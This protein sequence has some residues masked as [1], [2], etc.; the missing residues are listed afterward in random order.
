[1]SRGIISL[2][3]YLSKSLITPSQLTA[4]AKP[5][6]SLQTHPDL[7]FRFP[8]DLTLQQQGGWGFTLPPEAYS[9]ALHIQTVDQVTQGEW[10][11]TPSQSNE[12]LQISQSHYSST[13]VSAEI[14]CLATVLQLL[15]RNQKNEIYY[16]SPSK[17]SVKY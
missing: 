7:S 4:P 12:G 17:K 9:M 13:N 16:D 2:P 15:Y 8:V 3:E 6:L 5:C 11:K 1:M 14:H 10:G